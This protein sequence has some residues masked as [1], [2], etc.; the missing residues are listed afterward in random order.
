MDT[1]LLASAFSLWTSE[2]MSS[3]SCCQDGHHLAG[4]RLQPLDLREDVLLLLLPGWTPSCWLP[5]SASGPQRGCPP[6]PA[7]R[8]DTILL[9]SAFSLWTSERM[10]SFSCC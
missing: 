9:A 6:S 10:S 5:P 3:F 7:A 4:F 8:M 2:R 1:I